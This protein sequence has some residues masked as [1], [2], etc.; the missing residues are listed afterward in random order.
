MIIVVDTQA[1]EFWF[2]LAGSFIGQYPRLSS[3]VLTQRTQ[4]MRGA[5]EKG[6]SAW[7]SKDRPHLVLLMK[8]PQDPFLWD[9]VFRVL[10]EIFN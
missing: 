5:L 9:I 8:T 7:T 2:L 10:P 3:L 6:T 1:S 4:R